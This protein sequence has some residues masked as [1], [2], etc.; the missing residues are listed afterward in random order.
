[1]RLEFLVDDIMI[2]VG[3]AFFMMSSADPTS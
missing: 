3:F 2:V 1:L